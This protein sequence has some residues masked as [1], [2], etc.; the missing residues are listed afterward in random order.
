MARPSSPILSAEKIAQAALALVDASGEFTVGA[1]AD[2]LGVRPSSLYNHV[3]G[4]NDIVEGM[5]ALMLSDI[6]LK[7]DPNS[8]WDEA[9]PLLLRA[10]RDA[11]ARHPRLIPMLTSYTVVSEQVMRM[12]G[13]MATILR[14]SGVPDELLLDA[15]TIMDSYVLGAALD[16]AAPDEVWDSSAATSDAM[17]AAID[18]APIGRARAD[19][20]FEIGLRVMLDGLRA[21]ANEADA[22]SSTLEG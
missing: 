8:S 11:F 15:I 20:S 1:V 12:Y 4:R 18:A 16:V 9:F 22:T 17:H 10:Y 7:L 14:R 21:L 3:S 19:R 13:V 5:R 2:R 6:A